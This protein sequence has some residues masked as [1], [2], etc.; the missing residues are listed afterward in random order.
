MLKRCRSWLTLMPLAFIA[1]SRSGVAAP[2]GTVQFVLVAPL[3]SSII[4][5]QFSIDGVKVGTDTFRVAVPGVHATSRG[6]PAPAGE[7]MIGAQVTGVYVW[8][9][10]TVTVGAGQTVAD[11]LAF[12]CS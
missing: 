8:P 1:C 10:T 6:F 5:V 3:C 9:V 11:S 2:S 7:H 4:P 12:Y